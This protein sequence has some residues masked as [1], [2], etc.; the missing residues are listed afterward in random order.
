[1]D[2]EAAIDQA[3]DII[4]T[5]Q[6]QV[7][8]QTAAASQINGMSRKDQILKVML[9]EGPAS[10]PGPHVT[11]SRLAQALGTNN[12]NVS[13]MLTAVRDAG[14]SVAT[15]DLGRKF[16]L[17]YTPGVSKKNSKFVDDTDDT[18]NTISDISPDQLT[19][20]ISAAAGI[21]TKRLS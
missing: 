18:T 7:Q 11:I 5:Q 19:A 21:V 1:M 15:D 12:K 14:Y 10:I 2:L 4:K 16:I 9:P 8:T 3:M 6:V 17:S 13:S 20:S